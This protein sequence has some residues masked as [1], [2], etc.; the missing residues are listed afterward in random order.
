MSK[1]ARER[2]IRAFSAVFNGLDE[3]KIPG[4]SAGSTEAWDSLAAVML[5]SVVQQEF[6]VE[7][8]LE[9]RASLDSFEKILNRVRQNE[10]AD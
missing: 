2:L 8:S 4:L 3:E 9:E 7:F 10:P 1:S 5:L 6:A